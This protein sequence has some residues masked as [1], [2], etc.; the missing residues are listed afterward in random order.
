AGAVFTLEIKQGENWKPIREETELKTGEDGHLTVEALEE[1][2]YRFTEIQAPDGYVLN[3]QP[4]EFTL[5]KNADGV[6]P[7]LT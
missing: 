5:V 6:I 7:A 2:T 4:I 3:T 1:G